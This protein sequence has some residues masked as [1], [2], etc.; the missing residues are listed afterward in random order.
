[1]SMASK[2]ICSTY[3]LAYRMMSYV[4]KRTMYYEARVVPTE[5]WATSVPLLQDPTHYWGRFRVSGT[6]SGHEIS[7]VNT[8]SYVNYLASISATHRVTQGQLPVVW[9]PCNS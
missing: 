4:V 7:H 5:G 2:R 8:D 9:P 1:M 3:S 6:G